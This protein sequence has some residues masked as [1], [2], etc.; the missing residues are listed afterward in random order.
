MRVAAKHVDRSDLFLQQLLQT[1]AREVFWLTGNGRGLVRSGC[2]QPERGGETDRKDP[3]A[4]LNHRFDAADFALK[5]QVGQEEI[6]KLPK[7]EAGFY[8]A[9]TTSGK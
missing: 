6:R 1:H 9:Q 2:A 5:A 3:T 8:L 4:P 7:I